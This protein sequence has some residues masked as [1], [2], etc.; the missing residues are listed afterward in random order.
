MSSTHEE[1]L[2]ASTPLPAAHWSVRVRTMTGRELVVTCPRGALTTV[3]DVKRDLK[4]QHRA[5]AV[6]AQ[7]LMLPPAHKEEE[8]HENS[9]DR[10][11]ASKNQH[12]EPLADECT[13]DACGL[14]DQGA[15]EL[16]V[17][18]PEW[19]ERD[20]T[21]VNEVETGGVCINMS[22]RRLDEQAA[23]PIAWALLNEVRMSTRVPFFTRPEIIF[24]H[25]LFVF[26]LSARRSIRSSNPSIL[27][28]MRSATRA[29]S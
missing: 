9:S 7:R 20:Q 10:K 18:N 1:H 12:L 17:Q 14:G 24:F 25:V 4:R 27:A 8:D 16:L 5:L 15:L 3:G 28:A 26:Y 21:L 6:E 22:G 23:K 29:P 19:S 2:D 11:Q 13:L